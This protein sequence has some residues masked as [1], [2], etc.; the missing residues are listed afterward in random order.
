MGTSKIRERGG[1]PVL[2]PAEVLGRVDALASELGL[3]RPHGRR[4]GRP[5]RV[6]LLS[7]LFAALPH[8]ELVARARAEPRRV[9][10]YPPRVYVACAS[11]DVRLAEDA[12]ARLRDLGC[13]VTYDWTPDVSALASSLADPAVARAAVEADV[14]GVAR[15]ECL[16]V[17]DG[18]PSYG[19]TV[20]LGAGIMRALHDGLPIVQWGTGGDLTRGRIWETAVTERHVQL[21]DACDAA[22]AAA[23]AY[24]AR[25]AFV[26]HG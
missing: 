13:E 20:E 7:L 23:L 15:A 24:R 18:A 3:L 4:A 16:L 14:R 2:L 5:D 9:T 10:D 22:R 6:A 12:I 17:V 19:R 8:E 21:S 26:T 11:A 1:R 25:G